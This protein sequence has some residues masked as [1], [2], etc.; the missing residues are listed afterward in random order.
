MK[1][2]RTATFPLGKYHVH[3][4]HV[5]GLCEVPETKPPKSFDMYIPPDNTQEGLSVSIHEFMH[6]C[7][8]PDK[9]IHDMDAPVHIGR[10]L[11]RLGWR[12]EEKEEE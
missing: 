11:W 4:E 8:I 12:R 5:L 3:Q 7:G 10:L 2:V 6:A 9:Y 1:P